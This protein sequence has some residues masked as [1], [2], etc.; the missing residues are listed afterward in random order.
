MNELDVIRALRPHFDEVIV[1]AGEQLATEG[2]LAH[3]F[4][5]VVDGTLETCRGGVS[6]ELVAG[7]AFGC[8]AMRDRGVNEASVRALTDARLLV[9]SHAQFRAAE[10]TWPN[11]APQE[12]RFPRRALPTSVRSLPQ[13]ARQRGA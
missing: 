11:A 8:T 1:R 6:G 10:A 12:R 4:F 13:P 9:M 5:L 2:R 3:Q 7:Q